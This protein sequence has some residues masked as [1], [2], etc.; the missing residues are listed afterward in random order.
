MAIDHYRYSQQ[1]SVADKSPG[2]GTEDRMIYL[3]LPA[4]KRRQDPGSHTFCAKYL[5]HK[6]TKH[7]KQR[8]EGPHSQL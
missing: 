6:Y 7:T 8:C 1:N 2:L 4:K 5:Q 3:V